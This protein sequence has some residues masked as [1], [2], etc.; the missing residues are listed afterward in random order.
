MI[1]SFTISVLTAVLLKV[2]LDILTR[3]EHHVH[4]FFADRSKV[5]G[6]L[7]VWVVLFLSKFVILEVVDIVFGDEVE[8]GKFLDVVILII[9]MMVA[10]LLNRRAY[11]ALGVSDDA[12][13]GAD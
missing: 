7:S 2:L 8:L 1:E 11:D 6:V 5:L 3:V 4:G 9:T 10:Q 12:A 13:A